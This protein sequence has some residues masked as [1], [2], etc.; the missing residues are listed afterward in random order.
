MPIGYLRKVRF[1]QEK[2]FGV[3]DILTKDGRTFKF[4]LESL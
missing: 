3:I 4:K 1:L 2:K